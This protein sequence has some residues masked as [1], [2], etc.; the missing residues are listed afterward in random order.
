M[1]FKDNLKLLKIELNEIKK[2]YIEK[3]RES[4]FWDAK[5]QS[6]AEIKSELK[7]KQG[8]FG[9]IN[10]SQKEIHKMQ[11]CN[12]YN[13]PSNNFSQPLLYLLI[14]H[15]NSYSCIL[16]IKVIKFVLY[17]IILFADNGK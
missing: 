2:T 9:D 12:S 17:T 8:I 7:N 6:L 15:S 11:V 16:C 14:N 3:Q 1:E 10:D 13:Y 5:V 4:K